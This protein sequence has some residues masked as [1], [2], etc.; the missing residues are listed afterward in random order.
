[1]TNMVDTL[2]EAIESN[3]PQNR[4]LLSEF[5]D[6]VSTRTIPNE[7]VIRWLKAVHKYSIS[8]EDTAFLTKKMM[9]S[10]TV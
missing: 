7:E 8:A 5:L 9:N 4:T 2:I 10:G 3:T 1:M 6:H